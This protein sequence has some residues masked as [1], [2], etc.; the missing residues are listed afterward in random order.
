MP[1]I[2]TKPAYLSLAV[3]LVSLFGF[4]VSAQTYVYVEKDGTR[5]ITDHAIANKNFTYVAKY[6]RPTASISCTGVTADILE[7][8]ALHYMTDIFRLAEERNISPYLVKAVIAVESCFDARA[9]SRAGAKGLMQL[10]PETARQYNVY[11][12]FHAEDNLRAGIT[13]LSELLQHFNNNLE[14]ALAAYNAGI[15][16]VK[17]YQNVP[18]YTE[19]RDYI[20]KVLRYYRQYLSHHT[21][22]Q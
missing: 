17:K 2:K 8:R 7:R 1:G 4:S 6:G 13:H 14:F 9:V 11:D 20:K 21:Q 12:R 19:T 16:A 18:P 22:P 5:W 15:T 10:M 3:L